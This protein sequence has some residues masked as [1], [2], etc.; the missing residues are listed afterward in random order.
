MEE[1]R[2]GRKGREG[3][4]KDDAAVLELPPP[5]L[6]FAEQ[7]KSSIHREVVLPLPLH[8]ASFLLQAANL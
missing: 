5:P 3:A 2:Q 1:A 6:A 7:S 4:W 8:A